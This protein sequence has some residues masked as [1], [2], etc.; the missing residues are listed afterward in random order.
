[1][2]LYYR[3]SAPLNIVEN[4]WDNW[5]KAYSSLIEKIVQRV[6]EKEQNRVM[7]RRNGKGE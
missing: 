5:R 3:D 2:I 1:M 6:R 7:A 4:F